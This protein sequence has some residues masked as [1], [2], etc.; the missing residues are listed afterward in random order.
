MQQLEKGVIELDGKVAS[1]LPGFEGEHIICPLELV[2]E[3]NVGY[4]V[5]SWRQGECNS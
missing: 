4:T 3:A 2:M 5:L 1:Y